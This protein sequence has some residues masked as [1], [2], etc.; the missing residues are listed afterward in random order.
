MMSYSEY[1]DN[2][3]VERTFYVA[4]HYVREAVINLRLTAMLKT[5][6]PEIVRLVADLE[7]MRLR[8]RIQGSK[9]GDIIRDS[10]F[11]D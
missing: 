7:A 11:D 8:I 1:V 3:T 2:A 6:D 10:F 9:Y 5:E 4:E